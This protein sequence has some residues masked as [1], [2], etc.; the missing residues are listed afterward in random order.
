MASTGVD[1]QNYQPQKTVVKKVAKINHLGWSVKGN[2]VANLD[3]LRN[4]CSGK[5]MKSDFY[6]ALMF[7]EPQDQKETL[8]SQIEGQTVTGIILG[9]YNSTAGTVV[10]IQINTNIYQMVITEPLGTP[11]NKLK[12]QAKNGIMGQRIDVIPIHVNCHGII[13]YK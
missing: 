2:E 9:Y 3:I 7:S 13:H 8:A 4:M 11:P 1:F 10:D 5:R 6:T 12:D